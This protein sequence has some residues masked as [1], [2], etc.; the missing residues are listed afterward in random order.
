MA[1]REPKPAK[2]SGTVPSAEAAYMCGWP[3]VS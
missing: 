1:Q 3:D 2:E